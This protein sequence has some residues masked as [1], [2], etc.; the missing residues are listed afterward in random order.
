MPK[1]M[2]NSAISLI[3]GSIESY[4]LALYGITLPAARIQRNLSTKYAPV[5]GLLGSSVE[6]VIKA[7]IVQAKGPAA[8]Y[9]DNDIEAGIYRFGTDILNDFHKGIRDLDPEFGYIWNYQEGIDASTQKEMLALVDK[10][11]LLQDL[12]AKGLHAGLGCSR[13]IAI[14]A[15][16]DTYRLFTLFRG[17]KKLRAYLKNIPAPEATIRDRE[18]IIEDLAG[19]I[20]T[21]KNNKEKI[22]NLRNMYLVLPYIPDISPDWVETFERASVVPPKKDDIDYL[23][24]SLSEA[25]SIYLL[26]NRGGKDGLPV[27]I[28]P[29]NPDALPIAIQNIKR[30]ITSIPDQFNNDALTANTRL[31]QN[32]IDLPI[33]D[34]LLDIYALGLFPAKILNDQVKR[35]TAQQTWPFI[36]SAYS[37]QGCPRPCMF[38]IRACDEQDQLI[39]FI[40][41]TKDIG[42]GYLKR[43]IDTVIKIVTA[44]KDGA[45]IDLSK[46]KDSVFAEI[47]PYYLKTRAM[48]R[49]QRQPFTPA[50]IKKYPLSDSVNSVIGQ[51]VMNKMTAGKT[52]ESILALPNL[53]SNDK[54]A[55][56]ALLHLCFDEENK[57]GLIAVLRTDHLSGY[58]SQA[59][60]LMFFSDFLNAGPQLI[61]I[62]VRA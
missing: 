54:K 42:N 21:A 18:A 10:F 55:A 24:R 58:K 26:K 56:V 5:M 14:A 20:D 51:F 3:D 62:P 16:T 25:H 31:N 9:K 45:T 32:R 39:A 60:K 11:K 53:Q 17:S 2:K 28:E 43:R 50:F 47:K 15:A 59:R 27:R 61:G 46:E 38:F 41:R 34:F 8:M 12:R 36:I 13:D 6:L 48:P 19:R 29:E 37:T 44:I 4:L 7:C 57:N 22:N 40:K 33:D 1:F 52:L 35:L 23:V 49:E 30:V